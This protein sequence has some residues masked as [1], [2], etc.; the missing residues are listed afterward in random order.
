MSGLNWIGVW[1]LFCV[2]W[3]ALMML[4]GVVRAVRLQSY[5]KTITDQSTTSIHF[6]W[7]VSGVVSRGVWL[8]TR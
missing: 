3:M 6:G 2:A 4:V 8:V 1:L 5:S 7:W